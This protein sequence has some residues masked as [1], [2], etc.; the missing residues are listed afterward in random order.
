CDECQARSVG[1]VRYPTTLAPASGSV[2]VA[3]QCADNAHV[4]TGFSLNVRC[5]SSGGWSGTTPQCECDTGYRAVT[6]SGRQICQSVNTCPARSFGLV[7]YPTTLAPVSGSVTVA[8]QCADNAHVRT[9]FSLNVRCSSSGSW[10]GTTPQCECDTGY[11]AVTVSGRKI[12]QTDETTCPPTTDPP[13]IGAVNETKVLGCGLISWKPPPGNEGV[14]LS[15]VVRFFDGSTY[16]TSSGYKRIQR[17]SEIGRQWTRVNDIPDGRTVYADIRA[18]NT[19]GNVGVFSQK[20]VVANSTLCADDCPP[21]VL[22]P[23]CDECQARNAGLVHY[24]TTL[25]PASGSLTVTTQCADNAHVRTGFSLN[26][27]CSSSGSWTGTT[28][29]CECDTGYRAVTVSGRQICQ[30]EETTCPPTTGVTCAVRTVGLVRYPTTLAPASGSVTVSTQCADN[31][32]VR[33]GFSLNVRCSSSGGWTGTTPQCECD[34]GYRAVTV[35]GRQIC[36]T[37]ETTCPPT[38]GVTCAVR[39]V[40]LVAILLH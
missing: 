28:P 19:S 5:S 30:T 37:E 33:T 22:C 38:T 13:S 11:R 9:G 35:S 7:D 27:M 32:H 40:G 6:L 31:A 20:F 4:R 3:T 23:D 29:Q 34:T 21:P 39:T 16:D 8:T 36:Q 1:L 14:K 15:Y 10:T 26:V 2:T 17:N 12:C 24:P 25:A 18:R